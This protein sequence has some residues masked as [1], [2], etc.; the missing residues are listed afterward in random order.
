MKKIYLQVCVLALACLMS[1]SVVYSQICDPTK[2][3]FPV[4]AQVNSGGSSRISNNNFQMATT[5]GN[6]LIGSSRNNVIQPGSY[7]MEFG[8]WAF[9]MLEPNIPVVSASDGDFPDRIEVRWD[10]IKDP[11]GPPVTEQKLY[12]DNQFLG[13]FPITQNAYLDFNVIPGVSY[14][15]DVVTTNRFGN[16]EK[17]TDIGFVNPNG[18]I[19]G[20]IQTGSTV[21]VPD[22][23]VVLTPTISYSVQ[24]N[25]DDDKIVLTDSAI[26]NL[27]QGTIEFWVYPTKLTQ[28]TLFSKRR[29]IAEAN[30]PLNLYS[31]V[32][33][34]SYP[35]NNGIPVDSTPGKLFF[36]AKSG[37]PVASSKRNLSANTWTHVAIVFDSTNAK[38]YINGMFDNEVLGDFTIPDDRSPRDA[39][40]VRTYVGYWEGIGNY[41]EG[42]LDEV[43][44]WKSIRSNEKLIEN[45][46]RT[47]DADDTDL[48]IYWK[49]DE[50]KGTRAY[51]LSKS[52]HHGLFCS[53]IVF[54]VS[55]KASVYTSGITNQQGN[56]IIKGINYGSGTTFAATPRKLSIIG[57][58]LEMDG[59]DDWVEIPSVVGDTALNTGTIEAWVYPRS[60][61]GI[62][63]IVTLRNRAT[64]PSGILY[65]ENGRFKFLS[66][67][68]MIATDTTPL[69]TALWYHVALK[70]NSTGATFYINGEAGAVVNGDFSI[71][72][73][74]IGTKAT[75]GNVN[76]NY[77]YGRIDEVRVWK[78]ERTQQEIQANMNAPFTTE[79][80]GLQAYWKLNEGGGLVIS[81]ET[82][83][84]YVG[85][86][87]NADST[88]WTKHIPMDEKFT[89]VF[90]PET[91]DV[92]LAPSSTVVSRIDYT[93]ISLLSVV[94][95]VKHI[96]TNCFAD[97]VEVLVDGFP[98]RPPALTGVDGK[99]TV[100]FEPG[101]THTLSFRKFDHQFVPA[102]WDIRNISQP[103]VISRTFENTVTRDM[104]I[105][106]V[107]GKCEYSLG[108]SKVKITS[109]NNC[110]ETI[111]YTDS[112]SGRVTAAS[113]PPMNFNVTVMAI[114]NNPVHPFVDDS[115]II[116]MKEHNDTA[117]FLYRA[118][119]QVEIKTGFPEQTSA[120]GDVVMKQGER[121]KLTLDIFED[122]NGRRCPVD[123]GTI[124]KN[125]FV[126]QV[127]DKTFSFTNGVAYD[128][129]VAMGPNPLAPYTWGIEY[130]AVDTL[131]SGRTASTSQN[132]IVT[133][134]R[135]RPQRF[136]TI[137]PLRP[138]MILHDPPGDRSFSSFIKDSTY[139][140]KQTG[141]SLHAHG[142]GVEANLALGVSTTT[143]IG[144]GSAVSF[145]S[146]F[147]H[148]IS[149][150]GDF[151]YTYLN[152]HE[153]VRSVTFNS[154]Y[155]TSPEDGYIGDGGDVYIGY[156]SNMNYGVA[157]V[158]KYD[159]ATCSVQLSKALSMN[160]SNAS[161]M[162]LYSESYLK[163]TVIPQLDSLGVAPTL[164][165][166]ARNFYK[167]QAKRWRQWVTLNEQQKNAASNPNNISW[168]AGAIID[169][170]VTTSS[171]ETWNWSEEWEV[172]A[173]VGLELGFEFNKAGLTTSFKQH[174]TV[175]GSFGGGEVKASSKTYAYHLEDDDAGDVHSVD[176]YEPQGGSPIF[177]LIGG[178]TSCPWEEGTANREGVQVM[179]APNT[180]I[181]VPP[182]EPAVFTLNVGNI[183]ST[184]EDGTYQITIPQ[185]NNPDGAVIKVNGIT[186][187]TALLIDIP[188]GQQVPLTLTVE[189]GPVAYDYD[190]L[191][192]RL[193]STCDDQI[194]HDAMFSVHFEVPCSEV[195]IVEPT[196]NWLINS[197]DP[198]S[199]FITINKYDRNNPDLNEIWFQYRSVATATT[200]N[201]LALDRSILRY[202]PLK[203]VTINEILVDDYRTHVMESSMN[204][205]GKTVFDNPWITAIRIPK[206]SLPTAQNFYQFV[207]VIPPDV[208]PDGNMEI[209]AV[210][211][212][213]SQTIKGSSVIIKGRIDRSPPALLGSTEPVDGVLGPNDQ[214]IAHFNENIDCGSLHPLLNV[215]LFYSAT[216][217]E[218]DKTISCNE[219]TVVVTPNIPNRFLENQV[220][221][222]TFEDDGSA[223]AYGVRDLYDNRITRSLNY[224][225][226]VDRNSMRWSDPTFQTIANQGQTLT[227]TRQILNSGTFAQSF[228]IQ[229]IPSWLT[230]SPVNAIIP[231]GFTQEVTFTISP[232]LTGGFYKDTIFASTANGE[233]DLR[234]DFRILCPAPQWAVDEAEYQ[235]S[236]NI[237]ARLFVDGEA[238]SDGYDVV[239]AY[240]GNEVRGMGSVQYVEDVN[241]SIAY[242][243]FLTIFSNTTQGE[244]LSFK[245]WDASTCRELGYI[246]EEYTFTADAVYGRPD[247]P[248]RL[249]ATS[250]VS[251]QLALKQGWTWFSLNLQAS[252]MSVNPMMSSI[253]PTTND[254]IKSQ[255]SFSQYAS[256]LGWV[257]T[258]STLNTKSM[259]QAKLTTKDTVEFV[260]Y[261]VNLTSNKIPIV[262]GWNWISYQPQAGYEINHALSN[263]NPLNGNLI[264]S[265]T[266]YAIFVANLGWVGSLT[267]MSPEKGYLYKSGNPD[268]LKY[269]ATAVMAK[270]VQKKDE[271]V[272]LAMNGWTYDPY[273]FQFNMPVTG[274]VEKDEMEITDNEDL[275]GAFVNG[276]CRGVAQALYIE[277]MNKHIFFMLVYSN[278]ASGETI[279]FRFLDAS[280][281]TTYALAEQLPFSQDG[282]VGTVSS[283]FAWKVS[284]P[285]AVGNGKELPTEFGLSQ[286]YPNPFNPT[287]VISYQLPVD[288]W[289]TLKVYNVLGEEVATLVDGLQVAG[290]RMY[291]WNA[292]SSNG[293]PLPS[294]I[295]FYKLSAGN[296]SSG[297]GQG[298]TDTKKLMLM[299]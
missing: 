110:F 7:S 4:Q 28:S 6:A 250:Q 60:V 15:Y 171:E 291:E 16:S 34:G 192:V 298:F 97:S 66:T 108:K 155:S 88:I 38:I 74:S 131:G 51:D 285:L 139:S 256:G 196:N 75:I 58:A 207:W 52:K 5:I 147:K 39:R 3:L 260:G 82:I 164:T 246:E 271:F 185:E 159:T 35:G 294:G 211:T 216:G 114:D 142:G 70:Y 121:V 281:G 254:I 90:L 91:R 68:T 9:M 270:A 299:R 94:G 259:Y 249:T 243:V 43:R 116:L 93:D 24:F 100:E 167:D 257:G 112:L 41:F 180:A 18:I 269:P 87:I 235:Y 245:V 133:G 273:Q 21:P 217:L 169:N 144:L 89:H 267:F 158:I 84:S 182:D 220:L 59:V 120:C 103:V 244:Q 95:F 289:V 13:S 186:I 128:T 137:N 117:T 272:P 42:N 242:Q 284:H 73:G 101:S 61:T 124:T 293:Q 168:D 56:Y 156:A 280:N 126:S 209:R 184:D 109:T 105:N 278:I 173:E 214:I 62:Q 232:Q 50:G 160:E 175:S 53:P 20:T 253:S 31:V 170:S 72:T 201:T 228:T 134:H 8:F 247:N 157:D 187:E 166:S 279:E 77:F 129:I 202:E 263:L 153:L 227:F 135:P 113:L 268:T 290:Y 229:D 30:R 141:S 205:N 123:T 276:E 1:T 277:P 64:N 122:Y 238:T 189:R 212:C 86:I 252:D 266:T 258:L 172:N 264:K 130:V 240:V 14:K 55:N 225:F 140:T 221:R 143:I 195:A 178:A 154:T 262:Q 177:K 32:S 230:V 145:E 248:V 234:L 27:R 78:S 40:P 233:E 218:I 174:N 63:P 19:T 210:T 239:A 288:S 92:T 274:V 118:P 161:T 176:I 138:I 165:D 136:T 151:N 132:V 261:P 188:A 200:S 237:D 287:T 23:E 241:D 106:V 194:A 102:S 162:Y 54:S 255:T 146:G 265:Q 12:R 67:G 125:D 45:K 204:K 11:I 69:D 79:Q 222:L 148:T 199:V 183:S 224:E 99:F 83:N 208:V 231:A 292:T 76:S 223:P 283:P 26:N 48:L 25:G 2:E 219:N 107:G 111:V 296:P 17:G 71:D 191:V 98:A 203:S 37:T 282:I 275:V 286:N 46:D 149:L 150:G 47:I 115:K 251:K 127:L 179:I 80:D 213:F 65:I 297:T 29:V 198:D 119:I 163:G 206:D 22:V 96:N 197:S 81:D 57:R 295:Y 236:M 193:S 104:R 190:N 226:Y 49:F 10:P 215:K 36:Y 152:D 33:I 44:W 181:N 85:N